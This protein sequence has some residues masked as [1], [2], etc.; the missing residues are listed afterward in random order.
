MKVVARPP[1][2][3]LLVLGVCCALIGASPGYLRTGALFDPL[4]YGAMVGVIVAGSIG[5]RSVTV[6]GEGLWIK[7]SYAD[8]FFCQWMDVVA[9]E[10][11]RIGPFAFDQ[12]VL[13]E[14]VRKFFGGKLSGPPDVTWRPVSSKRIFIGLY[15]KLAKRSDRRRTD[16]AWHLA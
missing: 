13:R 1:W 9:V 10:R 12:L 2:L 15:D 11:R 8:R 14:P 16:R 7:R 4:S 6:I 5:Q 3:P